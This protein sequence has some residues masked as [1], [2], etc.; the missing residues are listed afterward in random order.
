MLHVIQVLF[1][2][3]F[4]LQIVMNREESQVLGD[5]RDPEMLIEQDF[6]I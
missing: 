6:K 1:L 4:L 2:P 3:V 5:L